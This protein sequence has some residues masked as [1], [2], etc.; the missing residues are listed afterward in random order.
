MPPGG[1][2]VFNLQGYIC[3]ATI[4]TTPSP[5]LQQVF[6]DFVTLQLPLLVLDSA[7]FCILHELSVKAHT[8]QAQSTQGDKLPQSDNPSEYILHPAPQAG[9]DPPC[10][11]ATVVVAGSPI[12]GL[13]TA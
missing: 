13:A 2:Q 1:D 10:F 6:A 12:A 4:D 7:D 8:F 5:L 9:C 11:A 3:L